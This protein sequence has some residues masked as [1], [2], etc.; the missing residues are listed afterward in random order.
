L[1]AQWGPGGFVQ[2]GR[3]AAVATPPKPSHA[4]TSAAHNSNHSKASAQPSAAFAGKGASPAQRAGG[5]VEVSTAAAATAAAA[6][7]RAH[8]LASATAAGKAPAACGAGHA[9]KPAAPIAIPAAAAAANAN[10]SEAAGSAGAGS[11]LG[12]AGSC[13]GEGGGSAPDRPDSTRGSAPP[14]SGAWRAAR[15]SPAVICVGSAG[16]AVG[17]PTAAQLAGGGGAGYASA[18]RAKKV[19]RPH[20]KISTRTPTAVST[21]PCRARAPDSN[22]RSALPIAFLLR[23]ARRPLFRARSRAVPSQSERKREKKLAKALARSASRAQ[24]WALASD[25]AGSAVSCS[26][27]ESCD[28]L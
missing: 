27:D 26:D 28:D 22:V 11:A 18:G 4:Q 19:R 17:S 14:A 12:G 21:H 16:S 2:G 6:A 3:R 25:A 24:P 10:A 8:G 13:P 7:T 1:C 20:L 15:G 23:L 5:G 9:A